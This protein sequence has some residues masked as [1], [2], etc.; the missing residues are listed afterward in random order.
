[1][2][3]SKD[4]LK[5]Q[6]K[7]SLTYEGMQKAHLADWEDVVPPA[8]PVFGGSGADPRTRP[9]T[10]GLGYEMDHDQIA[11]ENPVDWGGE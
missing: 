11:A 7:D 6:D 8:N 2:A 1:M 3:K 10:Y 9:W 4:P 5:G